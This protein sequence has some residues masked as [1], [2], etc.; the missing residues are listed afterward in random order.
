VIL[1]L[2]ASGLAVLVL[3]GLAVVLDDAGGVPLQVV[4]LL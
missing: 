1:R 4:L 3:V 2:D